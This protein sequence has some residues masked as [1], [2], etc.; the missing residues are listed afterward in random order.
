MFLYKRAES[1]VTSEHVEYISQK[2]KDANIKYENLVYDIY[3]A[4]YSRRR[5]YGFIPLFAN[6]AIQFYW[7][8]YIQSYVFFMCFLMGSAGNFPV[9]LAADCM[10]L[11]ISYNDFTREY[12]DQWIMCVILYR[13]A[14]LYNYNLVRHLRAGRRTVRPQ[15]SRY[16]DSMVI[17]V[18]DAF[19]ANQY[20]GGFT[21]ES[22]M[23]IR[24]FSVWIYIIAQFSYSIFWCWLC[25]KN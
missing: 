2:D 22:Y 19:S 20:Y 7:G 5:L 6:F 18:K 16:G 17:G 13:I 9:T 10:T 15:I 25:V 11:Y 23:Y 4:P 12:R 1:A 3:N 21:I 8:N 14:Q 24:Y